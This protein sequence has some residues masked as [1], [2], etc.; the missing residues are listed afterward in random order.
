MSATISNKPNKRTLV[1]YAYIEGAQE[2][3]LSLSDLRNFV[4]ST[5]AA[6]LLTM[7]RRA[8]NSAGAHPQALSAI[9]RIAKSLGEIEVSVSEA[10]QVE[11]HCGFSAKK[12]ITDIFHVATPS[13]DS[14]MRRNG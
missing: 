10:L 14:F 4:S 13:V 5:D 12:R 9:D 3:E 2:G 11:A 1:P 8:I 6:I 7:V